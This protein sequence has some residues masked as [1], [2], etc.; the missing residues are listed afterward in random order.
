MVSI[1]SLRFE[2]VPLICVQILEVELYGFWQMESQIPL[3]LECF[4]H[5]W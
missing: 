3:V 1:D 5:S 2:S 4:L